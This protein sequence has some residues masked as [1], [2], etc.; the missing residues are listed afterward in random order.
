METYSVS[1][2]IDKTAGASNRKTFSRL[3]KAAENHKA[4]NMVQ[5]LLIHTWHSFGTR[6]CPIPRGERGGANYMFIDT[7]HGGEGPGC[8]PPFLGNCSFLLNRFIDVWLICKELHIFNVHDLKR[9]D[10]CRDPWWHAHGN[11]HYNLGNRPNNTSQCTLVSLCLSVI[12]T[13]NMMVQPLWKIGWRFL[14]KLKIELLCDPASHTSGF[15]P[16]E[17]KNTYSKR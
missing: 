15:I 8:S 6:H 5:S 16:K 10:I 1:R 11:R 2:V 3:Q 14:K 9:L 12:T 7:A 4:A 17:N 13:L